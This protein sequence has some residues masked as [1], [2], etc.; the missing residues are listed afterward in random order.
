[1]KQF[2]NKNK[3]RREEKIIKEPTYKSVL[4]IVNEREKVASTLRIAELPLP[5]I[6][7]KI[8]K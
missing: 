3:R 8:N 5:S 4:E 1:M 6:K 2:T 7:M